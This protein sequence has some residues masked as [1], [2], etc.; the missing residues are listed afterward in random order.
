MYLK[1]NYFILLAFVCLVS[2]V[3]AQEWED[4][5]GEV[6]DA[7]VVIEKDKKIELPAAS[8][9]FEK[10]SPLPLKNQSGNMQFDLKDFNYQLPDL[11]PR[12]RILTIKDPK[13]KKLYANY[14]RAG[15]GNFASLLFEGYIN[16]KRNENYSFGIHAKHRSS[17]KGPVDG[18]NSGIFQNSVGANGKLFYKGF[19]LGSSLNYQGSKQHFYGY[20]QRVEPPR[21]TLEHR[22]NN[23]YFDATLETRDTGSDFYFNLR[24]SYNFIKDNFEAKES[25]FGLDFKS[26]FSLDEQIGLDL[27]SSL[28]VAKTSDGSSIKRNLFKIRPSVNF[29]VNDLKINAGV[30]I[31]FENDTL[32]GRNKTHV[33]L[34]GRVAY[35]LTEDILIYGGVDGDM[36]EVSL[37]RLATENQFLNSGIQLF[38]DNKQLELYGGIRGSLRRIFTLKSGFSLSDYESMHFLINDPADTAKFTVIYETGGATKFNFFGEFGI[39]KSRIFKGAARFDYYAYNLANVAKPWHKPRYKF[40]LMGSFNLF[41]KILFSS[42]LY[43]LG[44]IRAKAIRSDEEVELDSIVDLNFKV[45]YRYSDQVS[46]F[47]NFNNVLSKEYQAFYNY[48]SRGFMVMIGLTYAFDRL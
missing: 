17:A 16:N 18:K 10:I 48:P 20:D 35:D 7:E 3:S 23:I 30:N 2:N 47:M 41:D 34:S 40:S 1:R 6:E 4:K 5:T 11:D 38:H 36:E 25:K 43:T 26:T 42:D 31:A 28:V 21:D 29:K 33:Y 44:G 19:I 15:V 14:L 24:P 39:D 9:L 45:D 22:Y 32:A 46:M 8:R 37:Q 27:S 13:L 12:I